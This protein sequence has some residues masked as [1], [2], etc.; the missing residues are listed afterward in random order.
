MKLNFL[1]TNINIDFSKYLSKK[2]REF[3][4]SLDIK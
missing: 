4:K 1:K 3:I 2:E